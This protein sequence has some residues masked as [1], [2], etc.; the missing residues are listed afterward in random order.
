MDNIDSIGGD[1]V[2]YPMGGI[3]GRGGQVLWGAAWSLDSGAADGLSDQ[4][5]IMSSEGEA[6]VFQGS[7]PTE[8]PSWLQV[9]VYRIGKPLGNRAH[10]RGGGDIAVATSV[11]LV[12]LSK[13][14]SLDVTA[15]S[16]AAI[17][18]NIQDAWQGA[19]NDRGIDDWQCEL[20]PD[21]KMAVISPPVHIGGT[22]PTLFI[23][24]TET[25]AWCRYTNWDARA[26]DVFQGRLYFGGP[27]GK[28]YVANVTGSDDGDTYTGVYIP[29]F[30]DFGTP[31]NRK[32]AKVGR[33]VTRSKW[34]INYTLRFQGDF[35]MNYGSPPSAPA[36]ISENTWGTGK[37]G[38]AVWGTIS[39]DIVTQGWKSLGG[40]GYSASLSYQVTSGST[41]PLDVEI[42]R[43]EV[44]FTTAEVV[45]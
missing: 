8:D 11:G 39:A 7:S 34:P 20:W 5:V 40:A 36:V 4:L 1:P 44:T 21:L 35:N 6:A 14:I 18:Y 16:Q 9:G 38:T 32:I 31:A 19:V 3:F 2:K 24:N 29:L 30:E 26:M 15:L 27:D 33:G 28:I 23:T 10:F 12:P 45:T 41:A 17:S 13:A 37:W 42:I 22:D 25:G 43:L